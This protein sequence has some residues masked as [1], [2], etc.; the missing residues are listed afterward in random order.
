MGFSTF[1]F[2]DCAA[3]LLLHFVC[4]KSFSNIFHPQAKKRGEGAASRFRSALPLSLFRALRSA[5]SVL[6]APR[7]P[8]IT[9]SPLKARRA[10][11]L[12]YELDDA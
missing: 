6:F 7:Y 5:L 1:F 9:I 2:E 8:S 12:S 10:P 3:K 4:A 11:K